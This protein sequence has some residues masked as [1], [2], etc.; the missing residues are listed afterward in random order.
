MTRTSLLIPASA[1]QVAKSRVALPA[2]MRRD[3][4]QSLLTHT[5]TESLSAR[6]VGM[7]LVITADPV[8]AEVA[9]A[10]GASVE[11]ERPPYGLN[12]AVLTGRRRLAK[13]EPRCDIA[14]LVSDLP[15]LD[16]DELDAAVGE[17]HAGWRPLVVADRSGRGTTFLMH[18]RGCMPPTRFGPGSSLAHA[19]L[20]Y[21]RAR[22]EVPGL[23]HDLDT[24]DDLRTVVA[25]R[26]LGNP[27]SRLAALPFVQLL[28][29][30]TT[31]RDPQ[32]AI[33]A[34]ACSLTA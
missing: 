20:G 10:L 16:R 21:R 18:S 6:R 1:L 3:L 19:Q 23:R 17:F 29:S 15:L 12:R 24:L 32:L 8:L 9:T 7:V 13:D 4:A 25:P 22:G 27:S 31:L 28:A 30:R 26:P 33:L 2:P 11:I 34:N 14:V 5:L